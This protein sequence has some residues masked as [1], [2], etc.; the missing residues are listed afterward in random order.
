MFIPYDASIPWHRISSLGSTAVIECRP[1]AASIMRNTGYVGTALSS[2]DGLDG[3]DV[4][5]STSFLS[6]LKR[7]PILDHVQAST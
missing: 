4:I 5:R 6:I 3:G 2:I 1:R 7:I